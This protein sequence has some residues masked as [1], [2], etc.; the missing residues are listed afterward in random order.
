MQFISNLLI[1]ISFWNVRFWLSER[2]LRVL[3]AIELKCFHDNDNVQPNLK[4]SG[5]RKWTFIDFLRFKILG[6]LFKTFLEYDQ[7]KQEMYHK[8]IF[9]WS[10]NVNTLELLRMPDILHLLSP[11]KSIS[12]Y[13]EVRWNHEN[14]LASLISHICAKLFKAWENNY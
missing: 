11:P 9:C 8:R 5:I 4:S 12:K 2:L 10:K 13:F 14:Y 1:H 3:E 7:N 6:F